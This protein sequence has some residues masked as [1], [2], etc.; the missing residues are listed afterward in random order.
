MS[1]YKNGKWECGGI[2]RL[3]KCGVEEELAL[4]SGVINHQGKSIGLFQRARSKPELVY[5]DSVDAEN[6]VLVAAPPPE[7]YVFPE[8]VCIPAGEIVTIQETP[9]RKINPNSIAWHHPFVAVVED[10]PA[11]EEAIEVE[12]QKKPVRPAPAK[13][14]KRKPGRPRKGK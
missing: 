13:P 10:E 5:R 2:Y 14:E 6:Y 1:L 8:P 3:E 4:C 7:A 12:E 9:V 11:E